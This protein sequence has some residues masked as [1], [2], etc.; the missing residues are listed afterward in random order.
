MVVKE[1][2]LH[3]YTLNCWETKGVASATDYGMTQEKK[4]V[5]LFKKER[6]MKQ[7]RWNVN[8]WGIWVKSFQKFFVLKSEVM[9]K[10]TWQTSLVVQRLRIHLPMQGTPV[11]SLFREDPTFLRATNLRHHKSW[12]CTLEL[13]KSS[14]KQSPPASKVLTRQLESSQLAATTESPH[15]AKKTR[16]SQK[17]K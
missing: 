14:N 16:C 7:V 2:V 11:R 3:K 8:I 4:C 13:E 5:G 9:S 1:H 15:T 10:Q 6:T 12:A 17:I